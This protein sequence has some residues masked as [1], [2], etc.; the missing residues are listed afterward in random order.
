MKNCKL[1]I[2]ILFLKLLK[3]TNITIIKTIIKLKTFDLFLNL[4]LYNLIN[5]FI[6]KNTLLFLI[7]QVY[8]KR[9]YLAI[10]IK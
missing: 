1:I 10:K 4:V 7:G 8:Q 5:L 9:K 2:N 6:Q 3:K